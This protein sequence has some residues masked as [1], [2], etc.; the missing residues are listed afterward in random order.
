MRITSS[1]SFPHRA[2]CKYCCGRPKYYFFMIDKIQ[3]KDFKITLK[4]GQKFLN[5]ISIISDN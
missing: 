2:R 5:M 4:I 3:F 1:L